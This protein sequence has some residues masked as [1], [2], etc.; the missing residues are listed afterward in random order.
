MTGPGTRRWSRLTV[1]LG[2]C[3]LSALAA[4]AASAQDGPDFDENDQIVLTGRLVIAADETVDTASILNGSA[5]IEGTVRESVFVLNGD[6]EISG[7]VSDDVV[8]LNG[9][10]VVRSTAEIGGDLITR[11]TPEVEE[12]ATIRG[13]QSDVVTRFDVDVTGFAGRFA[14]WLGYSVSTLVLGLLLLL[15]APGLGEAVTPAVRGRLGSSV[16][17]GVALFFLIPI[18]AVVLLVTVVGI[19]LGLFVL[20]GLAL[21]YTVGYSVAPIGVG[22]LVVRSSPSRFVVFLV[23]WMILRALALIPFVGGLLWLVGSAWGLGLLAV[24]IRSGGTPRAV[25]ATVPPPPP[26]PVLE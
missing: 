21:I 11:G 13:S 19:P 3:A 8:V 12:G 15:F 25:T 14:W 26:V 23:G 20:L 2:A 6:T 9:D 18:A 5:L 22:S 10:V 16:G 1:F 7:T 4:P 17:W 24:A